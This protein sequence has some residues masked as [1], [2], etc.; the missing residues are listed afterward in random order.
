[1]TSTVELSKSLGEVHPIDIQALLES[2]GHD[3]V[4][5]ESLICSACS[6]DFPEASASLSN[7]TDETEL[8]DIQNIAHKIKGLAGSLEC[9]RLEAASNDL[10]DYMEKTE[11]VVRR[12]EEFIKKIEVVVY[13]INAVMEFVKS[14]KIWSSP[15]VKINLV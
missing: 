10:E 9:C 5:V 1:M 6:K 14:Q 2:F 8:S 12:H 3:S 11:K 4:F 15:R 13:E 7:L